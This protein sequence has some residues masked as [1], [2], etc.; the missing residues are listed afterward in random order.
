[1]K[2]KIIKLLSF[3]LILLFFSV[4]AYS[5][6]VYIDGELQ[7]FEGTIVNDRTMVPM[8]GIFEKLGADVQWYYETQTVTGKK[9]NVS[10]TLRIGDPVAQIGSESY[11]LDAPPL[12]IDS[13]T[14]VPLR[15]ISESLGSEVY[16]NGFTRSVEIFSDSFEKLSPDNLSIGMALA[17]AENIL[18]TPKNILIG[19]A[20]TE[21]RSYHNN[22]S[23]YYLVSYKDNQI[24][25]I[26]TSQKGSEFDGEK[27][28]ET[29]K[30]INNNNIFSKGS[31]TATFSSSD[32]K[33]ISIKDNVAKIFYLDIHDNNKVRGVRIISAESLLSDI[34]ILNYNIRYSNPADIPKVTPYTG[35]GNMSEIEKTQSSLHFELDNTARINHGLNPFYWYG[36][37]AEVAYLHSKDMAD[38][39]YFSHTSLSGKSPFDRMR[40][41]MIGF[42]IAAENISWGEG[43]Y[44][45]IESHHGL[46]NSLG[47]RKNI[48]NPELKEL[49]IGASY[50]DGL[51]ITQNFI[52]R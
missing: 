4:P 6:N 8:R 9:D 41:G 27:I 22:Y 46:M 24:H 15:F 34:V 35:N 16:W 33:K 50:N 37:L 10:V 39:N 2:N 36:Q 1:M 14:M 25:Y 13:R 42:I 29:Y 30:G 19:P 49:G 17:Q 48:L 7:S 11:T 51:Y 31:L 40:D 3:I 43:Y 20:N 21:L 44:D 18:G 12:I 52:S 32:D 28:G 26:F 45:A 47:H 5:I 38:N 23:D